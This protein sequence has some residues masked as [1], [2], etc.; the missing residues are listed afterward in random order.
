MKLR[1]S[2]L[3]IFISFFTFLWA[4]DYPNYEPLF[5]IDEVFLQ[6]GEASGKR[7]TIYSAD[8]VFVLALLFSECQ[9]S[10]ELWKACISKFE[11]IKAEVTSREIQKLDEAERGRAILKLLYRDY[12][13]KYD[14]D[15]TRID[16]ALEDGYY[17]CV[18]SAV[19][20]MAAAKAGGLQVVGQ[21]TVQHAFCS[22]Y[23]PSE[24]EGELLRIDV[25]TTNP[26]GF[27]PGSKEEIEN[28]DN[29]T[30][31]YTV[32]KKYYS[33]RRQTSD[34]AFVGLIAGNLC[35]YYV[36]KQNY[37]RSM[38]L[39][40]ARYE[41]VRYENPLDEAYVRS[42]FDILPCNYISYEANSAQEYALTLDWFTSFIDRWYKDDYIQN[43]MDI[44]FYNFLVLCTNEKNYKVADQ[45]YKKFSP[46][47][48]Q[49]Q[50][51]KS[52]ERLADIFFLAETEG[53]TSRQQVKTINDL[54][55]N[56]KLTEDIEKRA[57]VFLENAWYDIFNN[58]MRSKNYREGYLDSL[59]AMK[60]LPLNR[61]I[62][63]VNQTF[64]SNCIAEIHNSF[65][66]Q[67]NRENYDE[68]LKIL[69]QG[70][71]DFPGDKTLI[72]DLANLK[73]IMHIKE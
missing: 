61:Q 9:P 25:E 12:L 2:F 45:Y 38:P 50:L 57:D 26:F 20:Y 47:V 23:V 15:Q 66:K 34:A 41:A 54:K 21:R 32:P 56:N 63:R 67:A 27:N 48:S 22:V 5:S 69:E 30:R 31:Y 37:H 52:K 14:S 62:K 40:A 55:A 59:Q 53:Q 72:Q 49:K 64:Y 71:A 8:E 29:I 17:N 10:S 24:K 65:A 60:E 70:L 28:K 1:I 58:Y 13:R 43:I 39:A 11:K 19:L 3:F 42:E 36:K 7:P 44:S 51:E 4:E 68:A 16:I 46:Y 18:S 35:S 33:S 6:L 73:K